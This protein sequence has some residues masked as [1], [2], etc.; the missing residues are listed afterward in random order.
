MSYAND[1]AFK[2]ALQKFCTEWGIDH[3]VMLIPDKQNEIAL[4][5]FNLSRE[6]M[7]QVINSVNTGLGQLPKRRLD[8]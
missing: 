3:A 5:I 2:D 1:Q 7:T 4:M 6:A 8:S